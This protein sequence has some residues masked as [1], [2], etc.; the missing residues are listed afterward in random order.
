MEI[1]SFIDK[2]LKDLFILRNWPNV[3]IEFRFIDFEKYKHHISVTCAMKLASIT[4]G[5]INAIA[6]I[7]IEE[8]LKDDQIKKVTLTNNGFL[9]IELSRK[10]IEGHLK[11]ILLRNKN[12]ISPNIG[13]GKKI[14]L[15]YVSAN[16][17]GPLH[18][19]HARGAILGSVLANLFETT[20]FIVH[21]EFY[22]NDFGSQTTT[23]AKTLLLRYQDLI[24][25]K[26]SE[27]PEGMY[28]GEYVKDIAK[29]LI[30]KYD[31]RL[32]NKPLSSQ[33][34]IAKQFAI[35]YLIKQIRKDLKEINVHH[36]T[37]F[38][39]SILHKENKI[40]LAI[41]NLEKKG[42]IYKG[43]LKNIYGAEKQPKHKTPNII[44][45]TTMFKDDED[46]SITKD[47]NQ[48]S[49]F[50]A[51]IAYVQNKLHRNFDHYLT[52]LG[53]DHIG[54][55]TRLNA[56]FIALSSEDDLTEKVGKCLENQKENK[57]DSAL[58]DARKFF[59]D[60]PKNKSSEIK[61][62]QTVRY[63]QNNQTI[64]MSKR[65]GAMATVKD[66]LDCVPKEVLRYVMV[67]KRHNTHIDFDIEKTIAQSKSNP[68]FYINYAY[69]RCHSLIT[70]AKE[71]YKDN[72]NLDTQALDLSRLEHPKEVALIIKLIEWHVVLTQAVKKH[73]S[74]KITTYLQE[75]AG[76]FHALWDCV[77]DSNHYKFISSSIGETLPK[78]ALVNSTMHIIK[79]AFKILGIEAKEI[80]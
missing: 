61:V 34:E 60:L 23:L 50:G 52:I 64:K 37:F 67:S 1:F 76:S 20:G 2:I 24:N 3:D 39:E 57:E 43:F 42:L 44:F 18:I 69:A 31:T 17:T 11:Q 70:K 38:F 80:M 6:K 72:F 29:E 74:S 55:V 36:D 19:G 26:E 30:K 79:V 59:I 22:V 40:A 14:H 71:L 35:E 27:I 5:N 4:K 53:P 47:D 21:K 15:E 10:F 58:Q 16:P 49:Y 48:Y 73:E 28:P 8:L 7:I 25:N 62:Y 12:Y 41:K 54:Y 9:N 75:L 32:T 68:V 45:R 46:R 63:V 51:E 56:A 66:I 13:Q 78:L 33:T 65:K 77:Q